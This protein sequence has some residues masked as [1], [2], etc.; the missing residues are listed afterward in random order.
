MPIEFVLLVGH[1][2]GDIQLVVQNENS[3]QFTLFYFLGTLLSTSQLS[4]NQCCTM[5]YVAMIELCASLL[6]LFEYHFMSNLG[7]KYSIGLEQ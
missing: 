2:N 3:V 5:V 4:G 6:G 1:C 7:I